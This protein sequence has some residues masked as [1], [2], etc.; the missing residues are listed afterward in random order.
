MPYSAKQHKFFEKLVSLKKRPSLF[1]ARSWTF[2]DFLFNPFFP[3][4]KTS[5]SRIFY[6]FYAIF[7]F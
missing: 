4:C 1:R 3:D 6:I 7:K 2:S 5:F